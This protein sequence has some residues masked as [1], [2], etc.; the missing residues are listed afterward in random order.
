MAAYIALNT[1]SILDYL[2]CDK[3][4][5]HALSQV[6]R[7]GYEYVELWHVKGPEHGAPW[8]DFLDE[9]GLLCCAIHELFE[10]VMEDPDRIIKKARS[11]H[12]GILA[13]GRSR[14]LDWESMDEIRTFAGQMNCLG[15]RCRQAGITLIYHNHN[16]EFNMIE[17]KT[18]LEH[19]FDMT[20]PQLVGSELDVYWVQRSGANPV[21]WCRRLG[22]R[23]KV[24]HLKDIGLEKPE[25]GGFIKKPVCRAVGSG[26][27]EMDRILEQA[28][29]SGCQWFIVETCTD[30]IDNDS[31]RCAKES[32][33]Y[34][35]K[36]LIEK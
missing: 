19:F 9:A 11:L 25:G 6:K 24:L 27:M 18:A 29:E 20:D 23:L 28:V 10:E 14:D 32:Y 12:A 4:I 30:W 22:D 16:T 35:L 15:R 1:E 8:N 26:T 21:T 13:I 5:C 36:A 7:M 31:L 17:G 2:D 3:D 33:N 34:L